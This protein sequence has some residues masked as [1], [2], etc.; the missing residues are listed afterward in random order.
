VLTHCFADPIHGQARLLFYLRTIVF[1]VL[2]KDVKVF[3]AFVLITA[4]TPKS[5]KF[6][7]S[8]VYFAVT[9]SI[10]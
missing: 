3:R 10:F 4:Y 5:L 9:H 2:E 1:L 7:Q 6:Q 8:A